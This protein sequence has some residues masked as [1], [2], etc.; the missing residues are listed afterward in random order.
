MSTHNSH[1]ASDGE[2]ETEAR[3]TARGFELY[4]QDNEFAWLASDTTIPLDSVQ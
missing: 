4:E 1:H 2:Q 3:E